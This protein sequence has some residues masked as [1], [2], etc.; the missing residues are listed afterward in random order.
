VN[1]SSQT[2]I[3]NK[4]NSDELRIIENN[5]ISP[6]GSFKLFN[7]PINRKN[8]KFYFSKLIN[9]KQNNY[10]PKISKISDKNN[11]NNLKE[12]IKSKIK[13]KKNTN[14]LIKIVNLDLKKKKLKKELTSINLYLGENK[15]LMRYK[16]SNCLDI[17]L[18]NCEIKD[19]IKKQNI[20]PKRQRLSIK[21]TNKIVGDIYL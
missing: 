7:S 16:S 13:I 19:Y 14:V 6:K 9:N 17:K 12:K 11:T 15:K 10:L 4:N 2:T 21:L 8:T 5:Y 18:N 20:T 3:Y 1:E